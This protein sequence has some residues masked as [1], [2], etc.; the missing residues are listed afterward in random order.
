MPSKSHTPSDR[1]EDI[2]NVGTSRWEISTCTH[3]EEIRIMRRTHITEQT[4]VPVLGRRIYTMCWYCAGLGVSILQMLL[5]AQ[6][7]SV[8]RLA[9]AP[10]CMVSAWV[11]GSLVGSR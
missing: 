3:D 9:I 10:A 11:L 8:N 6:A 4:I 5:L 7:W 2:R 1:K